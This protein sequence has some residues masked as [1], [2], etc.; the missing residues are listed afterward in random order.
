M[1]GDATVR[2]SRKWTVGFQCHGPRI[3]P[4]L[5]AALVNL[6]LAAPLAV[7]RSRRPGPAGFWTRRPEVT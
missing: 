6:D 1:M 5:L 4:M 7:R 2:L 3:W